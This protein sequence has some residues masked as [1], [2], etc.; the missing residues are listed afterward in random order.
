MRKAIQKEL[1]NHSVVGPFGQSPFAYF[2]C[3]PLGAV[4]KPD[5][6]VRLILYLSAPRGDAANEHIDKDMLACKYSLF[7]EAVDIV[8]GI[9]SEAF[10]AKIDIKN[11]FKIC[12]VRRDRYF[13]FYTALPFGSRSSPAIFN[14]FATVL[15]W[16]YAEHGE[17]NNIIHYL[18]DYFLAEEDYMGCFRSLKALID[19]CKFLSVPLAEE[20]IDG[21]SKAIVYLGILIDAGAQ[22]MMLPNEK[23]CKL[24]DLLQ[25]WLGK[26]LCTKRESLSLIGPLSFASKF[27]RP[28]RIFLRRLID[29]ATSVKRL[30][31][32]VSLTSEAQLDILWWV[33]FLPKWN[34][35]ESILPRVVTGAHMGL[36]TDASDLGMG[37]VMSN[38]WLGGRTS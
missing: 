3:S 18:D 28:G 5:G 14:S 13:Y 26:V 21:P 30:D 16:I 9:G 11:A 2:H 22:M 29:L 35:K 20:K 24:K 7:D 37:G 10:M 12:P 34:G 8:S 15:R 36:Y 38:C 17:I 27:V 31:D 32:S 4:D 25:T 23:L 33:E 1:D 6:L 19:I